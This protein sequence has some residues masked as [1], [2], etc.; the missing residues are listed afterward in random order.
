MSTFVF[1]QHTDDSS[2]DLA[3]VSPHHFVRVK[4]TLLSFAIHSVGYLNKTMIYRIILIHQNRS[5]CYS[6]KEDEQISLFLLYTFYAYVEG[7]LQQNCLFLHFRIFNCGK[8]TIYLYLVEKSTF[9]ARKIEIVEFLPTVRNDFDELATSPP[10]S[11]YRRRMSPGNAALGPVI[12]RRWRSGNV[13]KKCNVPA[14]ICFI[15]T[16]SA[17]PRPTRMQSFRVL[18][19]LVAGRCLGPRRPRG[20]PSRGAEGRRRRKFFRHFKLQNTKR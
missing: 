4:D 2:L 19:F 9:T 1:S 14:C 10:T 18:L 8:S 5:C 12:I 6:Q 16:A 20:R 3:L 15:G 17:R 13:A 7:F 11:K